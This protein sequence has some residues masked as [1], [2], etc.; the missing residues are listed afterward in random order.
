MRTPA[1]DLTGEIGLGPLKA[2][3]RR[4]RVVLC[5]DAG[6]RHV[7]VAF[8][9]PCVV[10]MGPTSLE[11]TSLNLERVT[12][13]SEDVDCRPCYLRE[14][15]IDHRCS[16]SAERAA[17]AASRAADAAA[18]R[19]EPS[20]PRSSGAARRPGG[21]RRDRSLHRD[22]DLER[23]SVLLDCL[24]SIGREVRFAQRR[25]AHPDRDAGGRQRLPGRH[26]GRGA[27]AHPWAE[28]IALPENVGFA[29]GNNAGLRRAKGR[30][31]VLL[32][33][34]TVVLRDALERGVR[35]LDAHPD[36]GVVGLQLLNPD[37]SKQNSHP[38]L[39]RPR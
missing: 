9:V 24:D 16:R 34:D 22:R 19:G 28:V 13:L 6:A 3:V 17:L 4:A 25:R 32:N 35:Y 31:A 8:G 15:P 33:N 20:A 23:G 36:V 21:A 14:C 12:V 5:N 39:S 10:L 11:K 37:G 27:R 30:H 38:Q 26:R 1:V 18:L 29:A 2:V 7:A